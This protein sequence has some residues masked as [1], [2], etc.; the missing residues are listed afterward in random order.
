M[1]RASESI[2]KW[3][4]GYFGMAF[5]NGSAIRIKLHRS[6][7]LR[8]LT[9]IQQNLSRTQTGFRHVA[10]SSRSFIACR[11]AMIRWAEPRP[12]LSGSGIDAYR[13]RG[14]YWEG[15]GRPP[16]MLNHASDFKVI[17][18][19][20]FKINSKTKPLKSTA[21]YSSIRSLSR[22]LGMTARR[23]V[24]VSNRR[25]ETS[26]SM[27]W[28]SMVPGLPL[29]IAAVFTWPFRSE[30]DGANRRYSYSWFARHEIDSCAPLRSR[31]GGLCHRSMNPRAIVESRRG[32]LDSFAHACRSR[33]LR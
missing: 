28:W 15:G 30:S 6:T 8:N 25:F 31:D 9:L 20:L 4:A 22:R 11:R 16:L 23:G 33:W 17:R 29:W 27:P 3:V 14:I 10:Q 21:A 26:R 1:F 13:P 2:L 5:T 12:E 7:C 24:G 18:S 32:R 19:I